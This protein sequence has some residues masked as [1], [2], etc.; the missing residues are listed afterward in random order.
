LVIGVNGTNIINI[1]NPSPLTQPIWQYFNPSISESLERISNWIKESQHQQSILNIIKIENMAAILFTYGEQLT[2]EALDGLMNLV[3]SCSGH[4]AFAIRNGLDTIVTVYPLTDRKA[5]NKYIEKLFQEL[6]EY[7]ASSPQAPMCF[8]LKIGASNL[9]IDTPFG[10]ALDN[11][12]M[13]LYECELSEASRHYFY[14]EI[15]DLVI[16]Y[17]NQLKMAASFQ[18][19][20]HQNKIK[21]AYQ[22]VID[23]KTGTIKS[24][25][26][27]LRMID[28]NGQVCSAGP[29]IPIAEKY[30]FINKIDIFVLESALRELELSTEVHI[31]INV[32]NISV[33]NK[34]WINIARKLLINRELASRLIIELTETGVQRNLKK[35]AEFVEAVQA[36]GCKVAI[37]DFGAGYTSFAQLKILDYIKIDGTFIKDIEENPDSVLFVRTLQEFARAFG[38]KTVAEFVETGNVAKTLIDLG[39]D[40]L[41]GYYFGKPVNYRP[42]VKNDRVV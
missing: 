3:N 13:A 41:Q 36:L 8:S 39:V 16:E 31:S 12:F 22:P 10:K 34:E 6:S 19:I 25:E 26:A 23:S 18:S 2:I 40:Y 32:S 35:I 21:L 15:A 4:K 28:D 42:W 14:D 27:L 30:G 9:D 11:A 33:H 24:Y 29:L 38:V 20:I 7:S 1:N 17:Q 5:Y 37:D